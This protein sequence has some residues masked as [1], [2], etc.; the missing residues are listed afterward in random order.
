MRMEAWKSGRKQVLTTCPQGSSLSSIS[1]QSWLSHPPWKSGTIT[2][3][4]WLRCSSFS[5][6]QV[7]LSLIILIFYHTSGA[8]GYGMGTRG[9][10]AKKSPHHLSQPT[11][12][13]NM[14]CFCLSPRKMALFSSTTAPWLCGILRLHLKAEVEIVGL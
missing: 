2:M 13:G 14:M 4:C 12:H 11:N 1:F 8:P 10:V 6:H 7:F 9:K 3:G 5:E